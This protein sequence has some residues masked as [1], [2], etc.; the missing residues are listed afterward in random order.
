MAAPD[1]NLPAARLPLG[2]GLLLWACICTCLPACARHVE[3]DWPS[4]SPRFEGAVS[5]FDGER[6]GLWTFW[7]PNGALREQGY[8]SAGQRTGLWKQWYVNG[9]RRSE[10]HRSGESGEAGSPRTGFWRFWFENGNLEAQGVYVR[11]LREG[12]WDYHLAKGG[13][14]GDH[15][16]EYHRDQLLR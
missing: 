4:G 3:R 10:G 16:G 9:Q 1:P 14:D 5:R 15:S 11:G 12:R 7:F 2:T 6:E 8:Y 13:L